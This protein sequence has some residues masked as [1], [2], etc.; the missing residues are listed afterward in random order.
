M[1]GIAG[2]VAR[3]RQRCPYG[4][5]VPGFSA[6]GSYGNH[7]R[8]GGDAPRMPLPRRRSGFR[9]LTGPCQALGAD[10]PSDAELGGDLACRRLG[11]ERENVKR[12]YVRDAG[13]AGRQFAC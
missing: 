10:T 3:R 11:S 12:I 1:T 8:D 5:P 7:D 6:G 13:K 9:L 2:K 4:L